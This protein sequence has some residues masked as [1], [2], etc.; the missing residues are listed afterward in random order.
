MLPPPLPPA[1][2]VGPRPQPLPPCLQGLRLHDNPALLAAAKDADHLCPIFILD[3]WFLKPDKWAGQAKQGRL[4]REGEDGM[5]GC[6]GE[7]GRSGQP[8]QGDAPACAI[9]PHPS[10]TASHQLQRR[11]PAVCA[12]LA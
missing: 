12:G 6:A 4:G 9:A 2:S 5:Q 3:P 11:C 10:A 8:R 7:E 1:Q